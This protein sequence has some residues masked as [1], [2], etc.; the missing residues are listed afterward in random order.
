MHEYQD[1]EQ[2]ADIFHEEQIDMEHIATES[3]PVGELVVNNLVRQIPAYEKTS[4]ETTYGKEHLT[5]DK[6]ENV[7]QCLTKEWQTLNATKRQGTERAHDTAANGDDERS[8]VACETQL[9]LKECR[10]DLVERDERRESCERKQGIE[11]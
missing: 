2:R 9:L 11:H 1:D 3:A 6:V 10:A 4:E 7:E 5:G 8:L